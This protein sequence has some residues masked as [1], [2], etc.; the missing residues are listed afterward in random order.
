MGDLQDYKSLLFTNIYATAFKKYYEGTCCWLCITIYG[1]IHN[2]RHNT[3]TKSS[4]VCIY[5]STITGFSVPILVPWQKLLEHTSFT[6]IYLLNYLKIIVIIINCL[7]YYIHFYFTAVTGC[8][9]VK[10]QGR[11]VTQNEREID[12]FNKH[13]EW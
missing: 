5:T 11:C 13:K 7:C 1:I 9:I 4:V 8:C 12:T 6:I 10:S 2:I 3:N